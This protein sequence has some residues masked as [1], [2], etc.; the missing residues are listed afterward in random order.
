MGLFDP[1][2]DVRIGGGCVV[3]FG[4]YNEDR[5]VRE[6][7]TGPRN[8]LF[9]GPPGTGKTYTAGAIAGEAG[10][11][12][13]YVSGAQL[14]S[15]IVN[16]SSNLATDLFDTADSLA[17]QF[18]GCIVIMD[19]ADTILPD[20]A[21]FHHHAEDDKLTN[22]LLKRLERG[23]YG[24]VDVL[25]TNRRG[26]LDLA[27]TRDGRTDREYRLGL[28]DEATRREILGAQLSGL[29]DGLS[30]RCIN[31]LGR[32][33]DGWN[34]ADLEEIVDE[35]GLAAAEAGRSA[36]AWRDLK[37]GYRRTDP[38]GDPDHYSD[39]QDQ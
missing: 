13:V 9:Y 29:V 18:R 21:G 39:D 8:L 34:A 7:D 1:P 4:F 14:Q 24:R 16:S 32:Q 30:E 26:Q 19:E 27:A 35:A 33:T 6:L 3:T 5:A 10:V 11:P 31:T 17:R 20:R 25:I 36:I 2:G 12:Y 28:P 15:S 22:A 23:P 37:A 38:D